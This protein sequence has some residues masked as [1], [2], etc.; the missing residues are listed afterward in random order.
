MQM[1]LCFC[2]NCLPG[3]GVTVQFLLLL[4]VILRPREK[5]SIGFPEGLFT[6]GSIFVSF[7]VNTC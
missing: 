3:D 4:H 6:I 2:K 7:Y 1:Q 5:L